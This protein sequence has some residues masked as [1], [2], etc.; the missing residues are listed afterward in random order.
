[1]KILLDESAQ[2]IENQERDFIAIFWD[3]ENIRVIA[4]G[5]KTPIADAII[6][7]SN[8]LGHPFI[9]RV[10]GNWATPNQ[11]IIQALYSL[12]FDPIQG[13]MGK[14]NSVDVKLAVDCL[15]A[16]IV[17]RNLKIF[18]IITGDKDFI[19]VINWLKTHEKKVI[20]IS[21]PETVS[22]HLLM[23]ADD[24]V[25][26]KELSEKYNQH[27]GQTKEKNEGEEI[28][29]EQFTSFDDSVQF[30][31]QTIQKIR[32]EGKSTRLAVVDNYLRSSQDFEYHGAKTVQL[33]DKSGNFKSFSN[34]IEEV[35]KLGK[36]KTE[37]IEG[38]KEIF[39]IEENPREESEFSIGAQEK[40]DL[41]HW[42]I[43]IETVIQTIKKNEDKS[44]IVYK[45]TLL[46]ELKII[47]NNGGLPS[48]YYNR[49]LRNALTIL[50]NIEFI[51][52]LIQPNGKI[53]L[54]DN[55]DKKK[56]NYIKKAF[57]SQ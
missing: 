25:S 36:I 10:Y 13:S 52:I 21:K 26:L 3:Y 45:S 44:K 17:Y 16:A 20:I 4:E 31:I 28:E 41:Q 53:K 7:Y 55:Y 11:K 8:S 15:D 23:S 42:K 29:V 46:E 9:K 57:K 1:M 40:I 37:T 33:P 50:I 19:P 38:F 24:F 6:S 32:D 35:E 27:Y 43:I 14:T 5:I 48:N 34:F 56:G 54:A 39:L 49:V 18:I 12:G 2:I 22:E 51:E 30:L 47:R